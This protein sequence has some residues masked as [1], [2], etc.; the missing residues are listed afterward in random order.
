MKSTIM[1]LI[2]TGERDQQLRELTT[3]RAVAA[4]PLAGRYRLIDFPLSCMV[5]SGIRNVGI[6][7][8]KN[9]HS[10]MDHLGSGKEWDLH[11]K[12]TGLVIL[13]PFTTSANVGVYAGFLD[14]LKSN[15]QFL[16][17][18]KEKYVITT[19][20]HMLYTV[21]YDEMVA[22]HEASGA[23]MT[24]LYSNDPG[25]RREESGRYLQVEEGGRITA[26]EIDPAK[27]RLPSSYLECF[28]MERERLIELVDAA[29]SRGQY[30]LIRDV[31]MNAIRTGEMKIMGYECKGHVWHL[32]SVQ[33]YYRCNM[34]LLDPEIRAGLFQADR[35]I[36]TKLRDEMPTRHTETAKVTNS[37]LADGCVI[38][39]VVEN[40]VLFRGVKVK[41]GAV[42]RNSIIMQDGQVLEGA[43]L[44]HCILD[45]QTVI[46]ENH[47]LVGPESYP[48]VIDKNRIV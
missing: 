30:H 26:L 29:V 7:M 16:R 10:L 12:R 4:M 2:Y 39:G 15:L 35:P 44:D 40:S 33:A 13:P 17:R 32:D 22:Y 23:D 48:I 45:K 19:D 43:E 24:L 46:R 5:G 3:R 21:R 9:Y 8:Q 37:L 34:D 31:L 41:K 18:S 38:E 28:C 42:V 20:T 47:R 27:P 11:G 14:A 25:L 36:W 1:G 6:I